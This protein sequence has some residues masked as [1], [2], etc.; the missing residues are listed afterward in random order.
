M[1]SGPILIIEDDEDDISIMKEIFME[2]GLTNK[3]IRFTNCID[4]LDY[5][6]QTTDR[7]FIIFCDINLPRQNGMEFKKELDD[8]PQLRKKSIPFVFHTTTTDIVT[9]N[10][11]YTKMTVQG[12]FKKETDYSSIKKNLQ[13]IVDYWEL[14]KHPNCR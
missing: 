1:K 3:L 14:C 10:E 2:L 11:A 13:I 4:A 8:N 7:P 12:F 5:L 9:V 6:K